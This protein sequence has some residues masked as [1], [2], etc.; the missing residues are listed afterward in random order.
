MLNE[1]DDNSLTYD[2]NKESTQIHDLKSICP[3]HLFLN[4]YWIFTHKIFNAVPV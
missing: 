4:K 1:H 2:P 3:K